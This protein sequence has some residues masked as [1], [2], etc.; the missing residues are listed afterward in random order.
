MINEVIS[1]AIMDKIF[2]QAKTKLKPGVRMLY[3]NILNHWFSKKEQNVAYLSQFEMH[4]TDVKFDTFKNDFETLQKAKLIEISE[5][6]IK[7]LDVWSKHIPTHLLASEKYKRIK[8][9][10][11]KDE[12]YNSHAL[13]DIVRMKYRITIKQCNQLLQMFF[14]EQEGIETK[15]N[16]EGQVRKHFIY[17]CQNNLDKIKSDSIKSNNKILG[18][19]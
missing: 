2:D 12:L 8:A 7:F 18:R 17:W 19:K 5:T 11:V 6:K 3:Q 13:T 16:N 4:K 9:S 15:Y 10:E 14:L 1:I